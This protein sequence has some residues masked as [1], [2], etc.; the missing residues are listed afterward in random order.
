[1][2]QK[3][4]ILECVKQELLELKEERKKSTIP[5]GQVS[6]PNTRQNMYTE[7]ATISNTI[8]QQALTDIH[9]TFHPTMIDTHS[10]RCSLDVS[11]TEHTWTIKQHQQII[12]I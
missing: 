12:R 9:K 1:M 5:G 2:Y 7:L 6:N 4:R 3:N 10:F 8:N 11:K